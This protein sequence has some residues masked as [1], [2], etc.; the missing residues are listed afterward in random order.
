VDVICARV[1][2]RSQGFK[3]NA[4]GQRLISKPIDALLSERR[5]DRRALLPHLAATRAALAATCD[6]RAEPQP[7]A[8]RSA[9][10]RLLTDELCNSDNNFRAAT[11]FAWCD[12]RSRTPINDATRRARIAA[13]CDNVV[14]LG[15][16]KINP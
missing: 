7:G 15:P 10:R 4:R 5:V 12:D 1:R 16:H 2:A 14:Q 11:G 3:L 8:A 6:A 13:D 9:R